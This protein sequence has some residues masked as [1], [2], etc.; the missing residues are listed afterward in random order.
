MDELLVECVHRAEGCMYTCQ[1]QH[2]AKH[3]LDSCPYREVQEEDEESMLLK[4][5]SSL[6]HERNSGED[7]K[8]DILEGVNNTQ[9]SCVTFIF[10]HVLTSRH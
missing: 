4:D 2:L 3:L 1:R 10:S 8:E 5:A 9:A 6:T 7:F